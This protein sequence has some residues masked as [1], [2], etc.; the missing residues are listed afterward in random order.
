METRYINVGTTMIQNGAFLAGGSRASDDL[1]RG[2]S[3]DVETARMY[4]TEVHEVAGLEAADERD[5]VAK[6]T[7][8][9][10]LEQYKP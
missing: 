2:G 1:E 3:R 8:A 6:A 5:E 4:R 10:Q 9:H 7:W